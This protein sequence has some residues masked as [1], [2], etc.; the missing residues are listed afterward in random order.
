MQ[1]LYEDLMWRG[2]IKDTSTPDLKNLLDNE[3]I[4]FYLFL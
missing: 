1:S 2:L 3:K 4:T